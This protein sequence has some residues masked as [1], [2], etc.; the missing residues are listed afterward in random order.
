MSTNI[1]QNKNITVNGV[2]QQK[3]KNF[4]NWK[5]DWLVSRSNHRNISS[6]LARKID[7]KTPNHRTKS[8]FGVRSLL[9]LHRI[10]LCL[11]F[12]NF[13]IQ[14]TL[15]YIFCSPIKSFFTFFPFSILFPLI[16]DFFLWAKQNASCPLLL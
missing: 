2:E 15:S 12:T 6:L 11:Y 4:E 5:T 10:W 1:Y 13:K 16:W 3:C 9:V 7:R 8:C 14:I